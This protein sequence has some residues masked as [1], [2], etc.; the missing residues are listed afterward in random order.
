MF[1]KLFAIGFMMDSRTVR[2]YKTVL[3][4]QSQT[5]SYASLLMEPDPVPSDDGRDFLNKI[6]GKEGIRSLKSLLE[7]REAAKNQSF[8]KSGR[9]ERYDVLYNETKANEL[10]FNITQFTYQMKLLKKLEDIQVD[11]EDKLAAIA[12][13]K[14]DTDDGGYVANLKKGGLWK[15]WKIDL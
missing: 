12:E 8:F 6:A 4:P 14:K 13:Y 5:V 11:K 2:Q 1:L 3:F 15:D 10:I 7:K 9:D